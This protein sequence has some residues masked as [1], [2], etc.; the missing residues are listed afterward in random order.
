MTHVSSFYGRNAI[1]LII[2]AASAAALSVITYYY[3]SSI[4]DTISDISSNDIRSNTESQVHDLSLILTNGLDSAATNLQILSNS[5]SLLNEDQDARTLFNVAQESTSQL[6]YSYMWLDDEG[7]IRWITTENPEDLIGLDRSYRE[8]FTETK[9]TLRPY[10]SEVIIS[11]DEAPRL[12]LAY[13]A[14]DRRGET[15][16]FKG[17]VVA[18]IGLDTLGNLLQQESTPDSQR[19]RVQLV[20][21]RGTIL[22]AGNPLLVTKS[23]YDDRENILS[24]G[25][26]DAPRLDALVEMQQSQSGSR[27]IDYT[28]SDGQNTLASEPVIIDG[29]KIW[30][31]HVTAPHTLISDVRVLFDKQNVFSTLMV[32]VIGVLAVGIAF[33]IIG[34]NKRLELIVDARTTELRRANESLGESN[35]KLAALNEQLTAANEQLQVHDK[36]QREFIDVASHE[37]KTPTQAILLHSDIVKKR[38]QSGDSV[39]AIIRN[40]ERLQRLTNNILDVTRIESQ[41]LKLNKETFNF[42]DIVSALVA[43]YNAHIVNNN[44]NVDIVFEPRQDVIRVH[45]DKG[46]LT[47]VVSNLIG[48][49]VGFTTEGIILI[50]TEMKDSQLL[51]SVADSG[52][53]IDPEIM[54]RLFTKF[55]TKSEKGTGLG[56]FISK[57][58][59]EAHGGR[60]W[61]E[62]NKNGATFTFTLP[63]ERG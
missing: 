16:E 23:I 24:S 52:P 43:D 13:P 46:R 57:S 5:P 59:V 50:N 12:Y 41:T 18:A 44:M 15:D 25:L 34:S 21:N 26:M 51:V 55:T 40:A 20:D 47:Q 48:N 45:A 27:T 1:P 37:M 2:I 56:L 6:T 29:I 7:M 53:G 36:M 35:E 4:A 19:N 9:A 33:L 38:P 11:S 32:I 62:S 63:A 22:Y 60:I 3:S 8:Y 10:F 49:A 39:E 54:P 42:N 28:G 30:T 14:V 61:A 31:V 58:I 17:A